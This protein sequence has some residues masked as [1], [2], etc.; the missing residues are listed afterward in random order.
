M[1]KFVY[2]I[3][4]PRASWNTSIPNNGGLKGLLSQKR[5]GVAVES[6]CSPFTRI[7]RSEIAEINQLFFDPLHGTYSYMYET[8]NFYKIAVMC[9][10]K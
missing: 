5:R 7:S 6:G 10:C 9:S 2:L 3:S 8:L 4:E 1:C